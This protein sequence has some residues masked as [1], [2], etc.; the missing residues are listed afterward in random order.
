MTKSTI[1]LALGATTL[2]V[3]TTKPLT[4]QGGGDIPPGTTRYTIVAPLGIPLPPLPQDNIPTNEGVALGKKLFFDTRLSIN[5]TQSCASCHVQRTGWTDPRR[6]SVGAEGGVGTRNAM[7]ITNLAY[8]QRFFWDG[9]SPT[10]RHQ[11]VQPIQ[12]PIEM[13]ETI[14]G[15]IAKLQAD[16]VYVQ[17]FNSAFASPGITGD[18]IGRAIEQFEVV[19]LTG[20]SKADRVR[21]GR[22]R[23]TAL[24]AR[25]ELLFRTPFNPP[26]GQFGADCARCH[27]GP[28]MSTFGF[29]NNGRPAL[30]SDRGLGGFTGV[31]TDDFRFKTP[32]LRNIAITGPYFHDGSARTLEQVVAFYANGIQDSPNLDPGLRAQNGGN[33]LSP[34]DQK[35]LV[36]FLRTLT[37]R[38]FSGFGRTP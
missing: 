16:P 23:F 37:D 18:R 5:N 24:E 33:H 9:R 17:M 38:Q 14:P 7:P 10:I 31:P 22:E 6:F 25:G 34:E 8:Q 15:V 19:T 27:G 20:N 21:A 3:G 12:N 2:I 28:L 36:A 1:L 35:A 32:S 30:A 13:H 26:Q 11:A 29:I 4:A